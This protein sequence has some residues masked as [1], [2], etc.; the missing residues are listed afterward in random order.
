MFNIPSPDFYHTGSK[1]PD[2]YIKESDIFKSGLVTIPKGLVC[3]VGKR[4]YV[5]LVAG[6]M[7]IPE[8]LIYSFQAAGGNPAAEIPVPKRFAVG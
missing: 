3:F 2:R 4:Y 8:I 5:S 7:I 6:H 1:I